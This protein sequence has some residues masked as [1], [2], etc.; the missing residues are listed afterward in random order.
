M[1]V[2]KETAAAHVSETA[3]PSLEAEMA[4]QVDEKIVQENI[5]G[6]LDPSDSEAKQLEEESAADQGA[7]SAAN[8]EPPAIEDQVTEREAASG[9]QVLE[10]DDS[11][12]VPPAADSSQNS[13]PDPVGNVAQPLSEEVAEEKKESRTQQ[14]ND[15][16]MTEDIS[17]SRDE[18]GKVSEAQDTSI[19][20]LA[21]EAGP[22]ANSG[23]SGE[24]ETAQDPEVVTAKPPELTEPAT[25]GEPESAGTH[26]EE[27]PPVQTKGGQEEAYTAEEQAAEAPA[28]PSAK[29]PQQHEEPQTAVAGA[30]PGDASTAGKVENEGPDMLLGL[31][32]SRRRPHPPESPSLSASTSTAPSSLSF[33]SACASS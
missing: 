17:V 12:E 19:R 8:P 6:E 1:S 5:S 2:G 10:G 9:N 32:A 33:A 29:S 14:Q 27:A 26:L 20:E 31:A 15:T 18:N 4:R 11:V 30:I 28:D 25:S 22:E 3:D 24:L 7:Q 23:V 13:G 16:I 21:S